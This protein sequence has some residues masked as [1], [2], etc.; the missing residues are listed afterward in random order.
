[1]KRSALFLIM[2]I[3]LISCLG[4]GINRFYCC[5]KLASVSVV[6]GVDYSKS[7]ETKK[8][9]KCCRHEKQNFKIKD[10]HFNPLAFSLNQP[11]L[12]IIP[13]FTGNGNIA[14]ASLLSSKI[15]FRGNAPPGLSATPIYTLNCTYRI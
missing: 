4:I 9:E 10:S 6:Y 2:A 7:K 1:M 11:L 13:H 15:V 14:V 8:K 12:V 5:G 3:Y